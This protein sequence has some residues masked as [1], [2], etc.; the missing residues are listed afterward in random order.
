MARAQAIIVLACVAGSCVAGVAKTV[1]VRTHLRA[2][3][4]TNTTETM[5]VRQP[6]PANL[7]DLVSLVKSGSGAMPC[8]C[9]ASS[10]TWVASTRTEPK[11]IFIDLGA[12]DGNTL[13]DFVGGKYGALQNCP[14]GGKW[15]ATLVEANPRFATPLAQ[16]E[17]TH[18]GMVNAKTSTAAYMCEAKTSFYLDTQSHEHNY[19][20][21]SMSEN[22]V[23]AIK[24]GKTK[25]TVPTVNI[26]KLLHE[27]TIPADFVILKMDIEGAEWDIL[28]CLAQAPDTSLIDRLLVEVHPQ[29]WGNAGTTQQGMDAA[30]AAIRA[31]G[32]D[33]PDYFS[34][35][36]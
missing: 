19:W 24:S 25:V 31:K 35:T 14:S 26:I 16:E 20:G 15:E 21:S 18:P 2:G 1:T 17:K 3:G 10:V 27:T 28:P 22:H 36:L 12:A 11:C 34:Q 4:S 7:A 30:M 5:G 13:R 29:T 32:V 9:Q 8:Q 23:D 6:D 33:I